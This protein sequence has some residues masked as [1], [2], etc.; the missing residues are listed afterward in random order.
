M[1]AMR[2]MEIAVVLFFNQDTQN[3]KVKSIIK[4][5]PKVYSLTDLFAFSPSHTT[6]CSLNAAL[7]HLLHPTMCQMYN[8]I[9]T[10]FS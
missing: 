5:L 7:H 10:D 2:E 8:I 3:V 9:N 1:A 6:Y 4:S